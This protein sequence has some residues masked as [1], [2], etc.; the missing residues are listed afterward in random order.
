MASTERDRM[1]LDLRV[2]LGAARMANFGWA[3]PSV[4]DALEPAFPL[5][6]A[7]GDRDAIGLILWGLWVHYQTRTNFPRAHEWLAEL[8]AMAQANQ[9]SDL[10]LVYDMSAGCQYFWE[11]DYTRAL[12][13]TDH[14]KTI[15]DEEQHSRI[16]SLTN[17][18]PLVFSQHWAGSLADWIRGY[19]DRS[20][21]R[22]D[23]ALQLARKIGHPFNL[24]FALTAGA[25]SLIYL[26]ETDRF[27]E[28]CEEAETV[29]TEEA[30]GPFSE[31]VNVMQ[32]R[33][34]AYVQ[35]GDYELG[36]TLAKKGNDFWTSSGGRICTAMFRGWV[37][38][39]LRGLGRCDEAIKVNL[40]N[41]AHC[42]KT[43][44]R[45]M[46][47]ECVR[48]QGELTLE[49]KPSDAEAAERLFKEA[50]TIAQAHGAKSWELRAAMSL[51]ELLRSRNRRDEAGACL[52]PVLNWFSEGLE[53]E[54]LRQAKDLMA[55][56]A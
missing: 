54:D 29:A 22:M 33:G 15:Y 19:P 37:V 38:L 24:V 13:H 41:I 36:Y 47:P 21:E 17:H 20:V 11:A 32:W 35:R 39:G 2:A 9:T 14:L 10:P 43:G 49:A 7:F 50:I 28:H 25:T 12:G 16:T 52:E 46:E 34:G 51:A 31:H 30:L 6:K 8:E 5:A 42:R 48:L 23:E 4:A 55:A 53:T 18:D 40:E 44:D 56:L 26:N 3:H 1:E 27:L 45:Y